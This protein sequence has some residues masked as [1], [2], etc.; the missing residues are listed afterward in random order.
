M[1]VACCAC[2]AFWVSGSLATGANPSVV[3][4]RCWSGWYSQAA[5]SA[6]R[7]RFSVSNGAS[8]QGT[9][10][11]GEAFGS[12]GNGRGTRV[13]MPPWGQAAGARAGLCMEMSTC[14]VP[15]RGEG[16]GGRA[17]HGVAGR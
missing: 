3:S 10:G 7:W 16:E 5:N 14:N 9:P 13:H 4:N 12:S 8:P 15:R 17:P 1:P 11:M 6:S 2:Q